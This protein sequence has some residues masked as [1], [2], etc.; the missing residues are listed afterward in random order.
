MFLLHLVSLTGSYRILFFMLLAVCSIVGYL[1]AASEGN[2]QGRGQ[3]DF[4]NKLLSILF[5]I[6]KLSPIENNYLL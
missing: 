4:N 6:V 3:A 2:D 5:S 1:T